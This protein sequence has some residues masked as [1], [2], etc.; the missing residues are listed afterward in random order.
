MHPIELDSVYFEQPYM[1]KSNLFVQVYE[2]SRISIPVTH[3]VYY[4]TEKDKLIPGK[5]MNNFLKIRKTKIPFSSPTLLINKNNNVKSLVV[6]WKDIA[7]SYLEK[8]DEYAFMLKVE[9]ASLKKYK[10]PYKKM[11]AI[12][13]K[14]F[15][16]AVAFSRSLKEQDQYHRLF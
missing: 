16:E 1:R 12:A 7:E 11:R 10:T 5:I 14:Y 3:R 6:D 15:P 4:T 2:C 9:Q 8:T 13:A